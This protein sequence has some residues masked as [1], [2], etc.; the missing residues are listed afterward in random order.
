MTIL[1][2]T[3]RSR[4]SLALLGIA[5]VAVSLGIASAQASAYPNSMDALGDSITRAFNTCSVAFLDCPENS[6]ATGTNT[7]VD[8]YYLRLLTVNPSISG[9]NYNDAVS[10]AKM[11]ELYGQAALAVSRKVELVGI[12]MGANDAC[13]SSISTMTSV[14]SYESQFESAMK[15][16][17]SGIPSAQIN[18]SSLP[19]VYRLW[20]IFHTNLSAVST[21]NTFKICQSLLANPTSLATADEQRRVEVRTREEEFDST[22][23]SVCAKYTQCMYDSGAGFKTVFNTNDVSTRDYFHPSVEGQALVAQ[24]TW[25]AFPEHAFL[26]D[27]PFALEATSSTTQT[28]Q[29]GSSDS[30]ECGKLTLRYSPPSSLATNLALTVKSYGECIFNHPFVSERATLLTSNC[31]WALKSLGLQ[32]ESLADFREG[33]V[34]LGCTLNFTTSKCQVEILQH[35][36]LAEFRWENKDTVSGSYESELSF[37]LVQ[38]P[39]KITNTG[40]TLT[41]SNGEYHG[42]IPLQGVIAK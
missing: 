24:A 27:S 38:M 42:S 14:A 19:N 9:H 34:N 21:W 20:E 36:P 28:F 10:G 35:S 8:S 11:A 1:A 40:C 13:T 25:K 26:G 7:A 32:E 41:G 39:Y 17:T 2:R 16:L 37:D 30:V 15:L 3:T 31:E 33:G 6:W 18:V 29:L 4:T 22:L 12:L 23:Q 5:L